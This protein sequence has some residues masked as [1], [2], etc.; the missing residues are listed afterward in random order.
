MTTTHIYNAKISGR[1]DLQEIWI[2]HGKITSHPCGPADTTIDAQGGFLL[3]GLW[4]QHVHVDLEAQEH[5]RI[6]LRDTSSPHDVLERVGTYVRDLRSGKAAPQ[7]ADSNVPIMIQASGFR[8][9]IWKDPAKVSELDNVTGDYPVLMISGDAHSGW[10]N[11]A[12]QQ[13]FGL[14]HYDGLIR[15][16]EWF[17]LM[18]RITETPDYLPR[19]H[20]GMEAFIQR[21][22]SLGVVGLRDMSFSDAM[23]TTWPTSMTGRL[24]VAVSCYPEQLQERIDQG[25]FTGA[26]YPGAGK[27][28]DIYQGPLKMISDGSL[29][30]RTAYCCQPYDDGGHGV[31]NFDRDQI[32]HYMGLAQAHGFEI[33]IHAIGDAAMDDVLSVCEAF[34]AA[35]KPLK[36]SLEHVQLL[37]SGQASRLASLGISASIQPAHLLD[38]YPLAQV[39]WPDR[40]ERCYAFADL[41]KAGV[42]LMMGSDAPVAPMNPWLAMAAA[43]YRGPVG[44]GRPG[45]VGGDV[46]ALSGGSALG[47]STSG[48]ESPWEWE[49]SQRLSLQTALEASTN[50]NRL[51]DGDPGDVVIVD[52]DPL[53]YCHDKADGETG[54]ACAQEIARNLLNT[55][56]WVTVRD[57]KIVYEA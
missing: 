50:G 31:Q 21:A 40:M 39:I 8:P 16:N 4:D 51:R 25:L 12:A 5:T 34:E 1:C 18:N 47:D 35:G 2:Y 37:G 15:E 30:T 55:Q 49:P 52:R 38:D 32:R 20:Q 45:T 43:V 53:A 14:D 10:L 19:L 48:D 3:P 54:D 11:S 27:G 28:V 46:P 33:A 22:G 6:D 13:L 41:E 42:H 23:W 17:C 26:V 56:V 36:G 9:S 57:G 24:H 7:V 29:G 44:G